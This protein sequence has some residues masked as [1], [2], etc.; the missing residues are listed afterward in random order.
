MWM[1]Q[2]D[3]CHYCTHLYRARSESGC[4]WFNMIVVTIALIFTELLTFPAF[5]SSL[6][7][8]LPW[9]AEVLE[10]DS[11]LDDHVSLVHEFGFWKWKD[12]AFIVDVPLLECCHI[13]RL[14]PLDCCGILQFWMI[15]VSWVVDS[16]A[17]VSFPWLGVMSSLLFVSAMSLFVTPGLEVAQACYHQWFYQGFSNL[18]SDASLTICSAVTS[19]CGDGFKAASTSDSA[20]EKQ[21][22]DAWFGAFVASSDFG[23]PG[24]CFLASARVYSA[25]VDGREFSIGDRLLPLLSWQ[26]LQ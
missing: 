10:V 25:Y 21:I 20:T 23:M 11:P 9:N 7:I 13:L 19:S 16:A 17:V 2:H 24:R 18:D 4:E 3:C 15:D 22:Q 8:T 6:F 1:I 26:L 14:S 5:S 12:P